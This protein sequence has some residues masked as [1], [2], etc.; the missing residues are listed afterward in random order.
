VFAEPPRTSTDLE[1]ELLGIPVR[2][3]PWFWGVALLMG[4]GLADRP[5]LLA[6]WVA[7]LFVAI[8]VHELGHALCARTC[9]AHGVRIVLHGMGGLAFHAGRL[10]RARRI[11]ISLSGPGAG[12]LL[13]GLVYA[14]L[15]AVPPD[16]V[17]YGYRVVAGF[18]EW[19]CLGWGAVNLLP[20]LPLDGG[21]VARELLEA[22]WPGRGQRRA[23]LLSLVTS[24]AVALGF[25]ALESQ[26]RGYGYWPS[27][28]F[29]Y[30]AFLSW[31]TLQGVTY[32][33]RF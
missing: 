30:T 3:N 21:H 25:A 2:V 22:L 11:A 19:I 20:V 9:G 26:G 7:S 4:W 15:Q 13:Y 6:A 28:L 8:L 29:A 5:G 33:R 27:L 1:W 32:G 24:A 16:R 23:A 18:L 10:T 17:P 14:A 31:E 12:F